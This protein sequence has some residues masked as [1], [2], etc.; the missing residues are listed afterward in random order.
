MESLPPFKSYNRTAIPSRWKGPLRHD[1]DRLERSELGF[2][3]TMEILRW[4]LG[5]ATGRQCAEFVLDRAAIVPAN[6]KLGGWQ[7]DILGGPLGAVVGGYRDAEWLY[8]EV[9]SAHQA[10]AVQWAFG[11]LTIP[12]VAEGDWSNVSVEEVSLAYR[13]FCIRAHPNRGGK[14]KEFLRLQVAMEIVR[15]FSGEAGPLE[16]RSH[17]K[18]AVV[19][20]DVDVA[21]QLEL[22]AEQVEEEAKTAPL[23]DLES[24]NAFLDEY[25]LRQMQFKSEIIDEIARLHE[26]CAYAILG[27]SADASDG[28][29]RKAYKIAAMQAH[30]DKGGD[31][32]EFQELNS[33]YEKI[34]ERRKGGSKEPNG[35]EHSSESPAQATN[36][37]G[38]SPQQKKTACNPD[39]DDD[40]DGN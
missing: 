29:I 16:P 4:L 23:D 36:E 22:S 5:E 1:D 17:T 25:I 26:N 6:F 38:S 31:K 30:P 21:K 13:R 10:D 12:S 15:A 32:E 14:P 39:A 11:L 18:Q 40:D 33:A 24:Q 20:R 28:E 3:V 8:S 27:V 19:L 2:E 37:G 7:I 34:M 9:F 35:F